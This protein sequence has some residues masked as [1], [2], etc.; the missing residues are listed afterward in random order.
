MT[1]LPVPVKILAIDNVYDQRVYLTLAMTGRTPTMA[2]LSV[3][4]GLCPE[5]VK[6]AVN[7]LVKLGYVEAQYDTSEN[8]RK[9]IVSI[10]EEAK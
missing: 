9:R 5:T 1:C 4:C 2:E 6:R 10:A 7:R 3:R 8:C